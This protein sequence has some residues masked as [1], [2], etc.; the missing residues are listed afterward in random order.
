MVKYLVTLAVMLLVSG[1][2]GQTRPGVRSAPSTLALTLSRKA[3]SS[4]GIQTSRTKRQEAYSKLLEGQRHL[5]IA[6]RSRSQNRI[7]RYRMALAKTAFTKAVEIDPTLAELYTA[8][9]D[10]EWIQENRNFEDILLFSTTATKLDKNNF[11]G[12]RYAAIVYTLKSGLNRRSYS[13]EIAKLAV[14]SWAEVGRLDPRNAAAWA[15]L[16]AYYEKSGET[17]KQIESLRKWLSSVRPLDLERRVYATIMQPRGDLNPQVAGIKLGEVLLKEGKSDEAR[18][19]LTRAVADSPRNARAIALL[20][21]A[22]ET[23]QDKDLAGPIEALRQAVFANQGNSSLVRLLAKTIARTG[24]VDDAVKVL[25]SAVSR[26]VGKN[27]FSASNLQVAVGDIFAE[28]NRV[29]E[30]IS[31]Y[32]QALKIRGIGSSR[33]L[34][35]DRDF[36][37]RVFNKMAQILKRANRTTEYENLLKTAI[38]LFGGENVQIGQFRVNLLFD[39][40][41][42][43]AALREVRRVRSRFPNDNGLLRLQ[44]KILTKLGRVDDAVALIRPLITNSRKNKNKPEIVDEYSNQLF[45]SS[46]YIE[47]KRKNEAFQAVNEAL[48]VAD[49]REKQQIAKLNLAYAQQ[50]FG[51]FSSAERNL[52]EILEQTPNYPI[53]LN[54]LGYLLIEQN[55]QLPEAIRLIERAVRVEPENSSYL[56]SL[57]WGYYK[58]G[59]LDRAESYLKRA[60]VYNSSSVRILEHLGDVYNKKGKASEAKKVW[61]RALTLAADANESA[62]LRTKLSR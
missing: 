16:S 52:R 36:A 57:G 30:A 41:E 40:G 50:A 24:D 58:L 22:L 17:Q 45:I 19:V 42:N 47:A 5:W 51:D 31:A 32:N 29:D 59:D 4:Q 46:L 56:D 11:G 48:S 26:S 35:D 37:L 20:T 60:F 39:S 44:A 7:N 28:S 27:R 43:A 2:L 38:P 18:T 33:I 6:K 61:R 14:I 23:T 15:F 13:P 21:Q 62:R 8:L 55:K 9:A 3:T 10:L 34:D 49:T 53:A 25:T 12:H 1:A 54:N